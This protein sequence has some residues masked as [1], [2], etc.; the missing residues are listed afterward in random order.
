[1]GNLTARFK[2][3]KQK[4]KNQIHL[5]ITDKEFKKLK[6][7]QDI[8]EHQLLTP[9]SRNTILRLALNFYYNAV[10]HGEADFSNTKLIKGRQVY[11]DKETSEINNADFMTLPNELKEDPDLKTKL[12]LDEQGKECLIKQSKEEYTRDKEQGGF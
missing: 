12:D 5:R 9:A 10:K 1:M 8:S 3:M 11:S 4:T 2:R 7:L 6:E